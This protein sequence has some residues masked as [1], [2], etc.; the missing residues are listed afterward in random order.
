MFRI[1]LTGHRKLGNSYNIN[2][3]TSMRVVKWLSTQLDNYLQTHDKIECISGM[4]IGADTLFA[5]VV[6]LY[7]KKYPD[8]ISLTCAIPFKGQGS[9]WPDKS[10]NIYNKILKLADRKVIV[11]DHYSKMSFI[12]RDEWMVDNSDLLIGIWD[13]TK[14]GGTYTTIKYAKKVNK[15]I[16]FIPINLLTQNEENQ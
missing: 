15:P 5:M 16:L 4:A 12:E 10:Q 1:A 2:S 9:N 3:P 8:R 11:C 7:K 13:G 14:N 6:L